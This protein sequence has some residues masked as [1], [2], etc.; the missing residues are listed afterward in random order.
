M[1]KL[2]WETDD[3]TRHGGARIFAGTKTLQRLIKE[4][5]V[6]KND[7]K[8]AA[9]K[10][11]QQLLPA[12]ASAVFETLQVQGVDVSFNTHFIWNPNIFLESPFYEIH[13]DVAWNM[14]DDERGFQIWMLVE[15]DKPRGNMF[16]IKDLHNWTTKYTKAL[17][18]EFVT[19][20]VVD[21]DHCRYTQLGSWS[22]SDFNAVYVPNM[23]PGSFLGMNKSVLHCSDFVG[24]PRRSVV[25]MRIAPR[26]NF[27]KR[28]DVQC[29][30]ITEKQLE[31]SISLNT[32]LKCSTFHRD[33]FLGRLAES[34]YDFEIFNN[35]W[36]HTRGDEIDMR[37]KHREPVAAAQ[38]L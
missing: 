20:H 25:V 3:V 23:P 31:N 21:Q 34:Q 9:Q 17:T 28:D 8:M 2:T 38:I 10:K 19:H 4:L 33:F 11:F 36:Q 24:S 14:F 18:F 32:R 5:R 26:K 1:S 16:L 7:G 15:N 27:V 37:L 22:L 12:L 13:N 30:V 6:A 35:I 29:P